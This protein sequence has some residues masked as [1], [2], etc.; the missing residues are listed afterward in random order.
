MGAQVI[1]VEAP[2]VEDDGTG[3]RHHYDFLNIHPNKRSMTLNLKTDQ[4]RSILLR[5]VEQSDV[6]VENYR[7]DVKYRLG[8][9]YETLSRVNP[10][11][12]YASISG[13]GQTG[14][15]AQRPGLDQIAQG[16]SGLMSINGDP[17]CGPVRVGLPI[18]DL[19]SGFLASFGVMV[20]LLE[21]ERS[22]RGQWV[23][24]SL[25]QAAVRLM[26]FQASRWLI[27]GEIPEQAG[28]YHPISQ[29]TGVYQAKEGRLIIQAGGQ[30]LFRR[31]CEALGT[32]ELFENPGYANGRLRLAHRDEL[33]AEVEKR[34]ASRTAAEWVELL[35]EA[36]VPA[37]PVLNVKESFEN[38]QVQTLPVTAT[39][40][41]TT[42][43]P[44][45]VLASGVN[46]ERTPPS[47][48]SAAPELGE[49]TDEVLHELGFG[50]EEITDFR[51]LGVI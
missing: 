21:R 31:L 17:R 18:A 29:P 45:T 25:L 23:H 13:F 2:D 40:E 10:R 43:G 38:E 42:L 26:E 35:T 1:K 41:H 24:T 7:P 6:L 15:Y 3:D 8:I 37:G 14:P 47:M 44:L 34:L 48:R 19:T 32:P 28:N 16:L 12:V 22:G 11:L 36:G 20:A 5:M 9:D 33:T 4:G 50:D 27:N 39:V 30:R 51:R 49:H 46:L